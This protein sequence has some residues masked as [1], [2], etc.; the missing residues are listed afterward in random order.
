[1]SREPTR[2]PARLR[3]RALAALFSVAV[4]WGGTFV[5]M[6]D[7]LAAAAAHLG[8]GRTASATCL[9]LALRFGSAA[10]IVLAISPAARARLGALEWRFGAWLGVLLFGGFAL[11]MGGLAE[12]SPAVSAFLT[13]LYVL[14]TAVI[15]A[16]TREGRI[17]GALVAG[18]LL[19]TL[20]A[21]LIRG[22][23]ELG[24]TAG[25]ALTVASAVLFAIHILATDRATRRC[26]PMAITFTSLAVVAIVSAAAC[27]LD[28]LRGG[29][30]DVRSVMDMLAD[31]A[32]LVPLVLTT[33]L[34]TVVALSFMN[35]FQR[36]VDPVRAAILYAFEPIFAA[37][38][39][40]VSGHDVPSA[41]LGFGGA[42]L[43]LGNL[44]AEL[45][46]R[47]ETTSA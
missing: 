23:P 26:D 44:V 27:G 15:G 13:S 2:E 5:W 16:F 42:A 25:E 20:G 33:V 32:F 24:F 11:Q 46:V 22:R 10:L 28:A 9:F 1:M 30:P 3:W 4:I 37:L 8:P 34:A 31:R 43:F 12:V 39:G 38:F 17:S 41:W 21:G 36:Q 29:A 35:L 14:F 45:G 47:R 40:L 18:A 6:K 19:A 7:A